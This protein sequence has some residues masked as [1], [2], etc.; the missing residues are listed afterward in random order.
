MLVLLRGQYKVQLPI[1]KTQQHRAFIPFLRP[2]AHTYQTSQL[3]Q[4]RNRKRS[5]FIC[6][7][8]LCKFRHSL[9]SALCFRKA[10]HASVVLPSILVLFRTHDRKVATPHKTQE[11]RAFLPF[12]S[13]SQP[14]K[15]LNE[16]PSPFQHDVSN[17]FF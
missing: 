2:Q 8:L 3:L 16:I 4:L 11:H 6:T 17:I 10:T 13:H 5:L 14:I 1:R 15:Q 12:F 9:R 7:R